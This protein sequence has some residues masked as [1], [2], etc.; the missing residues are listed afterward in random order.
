[1]ENTDR[2]KDIQSELTKALLALASS[3]A[4]HRHLDV[5][6]A[7]GPLS[8]G[9]LSFN[10]QLLV[11][12]QAYAREIVPGNVAT[13]QRWHGFKRHPRKGEKALYILQ[14]IPYKQEV[15]GEEVRRVF[16]RALAVFV[17]AQTDGEPL[18]APAVRPV[19][20]Q[21]QDDG[22]AFDRLAAWAVSSGF[23]ASVTVRAQE[24]GERFNGYFEPATRRIVVMSHLEPAHRLK[25]L[26]HELTHANNT[27]LKLNRD[28][29]EIA[30][31]SA[32][33]IVCKALGID[34]SSYS[35]PYVT[36]WADTKDPELL[37]RR[38]EGTGQA[39]VN[40]ARKFLEVLEPAKGEEVETKAAA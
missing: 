3:D 17:E 9:R 7:L 6:A 2:V 40:S 32:A 13:F 27:T 30:A 18:P 21:G 10:N 14:P 35:L 11:C 4:W 28:D 29:D 25:T 5:V 33:Y 15:E 1:M 24:T 38:I 34:S 37:R 16:F 12:A 19:C 23:V 39:V 26:V 36:G 20:L 8:L 31:E 22:G